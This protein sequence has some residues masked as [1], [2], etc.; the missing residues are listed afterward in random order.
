VSRGMIALNRIITAKEIK[1]VKFIDM[2]G[3]E[4]NKQRIRIEYI[5][6]I[7]YEG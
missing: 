1:G 6:K 7:K 5:I 4:N 3:L 2:V